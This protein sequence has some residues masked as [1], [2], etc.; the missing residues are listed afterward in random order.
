VQAIARI[1]LGPAAS[2]EIFEK[3]LRE[4]PAIL[5]AWHVTGDVDYETLITCRDLAALSIVL[6][7]LRRYCCGEVASA[8]LVLSEV[9]GLISA[10]AAQTGRKVSRK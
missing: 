4:I 10:E 3:Q 1:R 2:R 7:E 6:G 9:T 5:A 8:E